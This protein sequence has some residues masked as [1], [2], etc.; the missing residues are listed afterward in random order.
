MVRVEA[1]LR[2]DEAAMVM[3]AI[4]QEA[5]RASAEAFDRANG[6]VSLAQA[7]LRG[8]APDRAPVEIVVTVPHTAL[9]AAAAAEPGLDTVG[10]LADGTP[11]SAEAC[12]RLACD[13]G[14][15]TIIEGADGQPLSVG[16]RTRTVPAA[17]KRALL[18]RDRTC[19][20]PGCTNRLFLDGHHVRH[21]A[22][23]GETSL[24]NTVLLCTHHH[25]CVHE[26]GYRVE[27]VAGEPVFF[28]P[29]G[30]PVLAV[31][32]RPRTSAVDAW[33]AINAANDEL[34][35]TATT[36]QC[37]WD[38]ESVQYDFVLAGLTQL[39]RA[40]SGSGSGSG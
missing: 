9:A 35:L 11:V 16:R 3:R 15:V 17:I 37:R 31:P 28:D 20:F 23:G 19:R 38:G 6:L 30:R 1:V 14:L 22:N 25:A 36:G 8:D 12:R 4:E 39:D 13:A 34:G 32:L 2:P 40:A 27:L 5:K 26:H 33:Y 29:R 24:E 10:V 18:H 21:W 7:V